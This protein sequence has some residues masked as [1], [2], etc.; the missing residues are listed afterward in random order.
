MTDTLLPVSD[1]TALDRDEP[2]RRDLIHSIE[3]GLAV[4]RVFSSERRRC[5]LA[6]VAREAGLSRAAARRM[7]LTLQALGYVGTSGRE[8]FLLPRVLDLGYNVVSSAGLTGLVQP[9]LDALNEDLTEGCS[10]GVMSQG[11]VAFVARAQSRRLL[12]ASLKAGERFN[13]FVTPVG[14]V[15][16]AGLDDAE[17]LGVM[18]EHPPRSYTRYTVTEPDLLLAEI[19]RVREQGWSV[20]AEELEIGFCAAAVPIRTPDGTPVAALNV[21]SHS[22]R[23]TPQQAAAVIVPK[24]Q[25]AAAT[26]EQ[27]LLLH[28]YA[29]DV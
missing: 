2:N 18:R 21:G 14:R 28:P 25:A 16:L 13:A 11:E 26:I 20:V 22:S 29:L 9:H 23:V 15:L 24:L 10:L 3:K 1:E 4:I 8:Y 27:E 17:V 7:L 5:T 12:T 19:R 6:D